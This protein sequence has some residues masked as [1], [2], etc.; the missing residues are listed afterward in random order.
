MIRQLFTESL[1]LALLGSL[2][3]L[4][5]GHTLLR[6][7]MAST[8]SPAWLDPT[9]D[10]RIIGFTLGISC[11][12]AVLFGLTPALQ[13]VRQRHRATWTRQFL[14]GA[15]VAASCVLLI[16]AALLVR[17][18]D[19]ATSA[20]PGFEY[21]QVIA[22][23]P[24]LATHGYSPT[25]ARAYM[26]TLQSRLRDLPGVENVALTN[27]PPFGNATI[28]AKIEIDGRAVEAQITHV[29]AQFFRTMRI[30]LLRGRLF[31]P[32][33]AHAVIVSQSLARR[34][35]PGQDPM[36]KQL[37]LGALESTV[38]GI[39][40]NARMVKLEDPDLA[41][42]YYP[43]DPADLP[44]MTVV[45][46]TSASA[47]PLVPIVVSILKAMDP[48]VVPA[49]EMLTTSL[50]RKLRTAQYGALAV[51]VLGL[52]A[53]LLACCG[54]AGIVAYAVSQRTKEIGIRMALGAPSSHV[55]SLVLRQFSGP[56]CAGLLVG[57]GGAAALSQ[58]LRRVLYGISSLDPVAYVSAIG[59]FALTVFL[60]ALLPAGRALRIDPTRALRCD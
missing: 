34:L 25:R 8:G 53:L 30:P 18:L 52:A 16:V 10:W 15:Q 22:I 24:G 38:V 37:P 13:V 6:L 27:I 11:T 3:G 59:I 5:V 55:V 21:Q 14:I 49:V 36:G 19:H 7:L 28:T 51:S 60:A 2:A 39:S 44:G 29:D 58:V 54:I 48:K 35:W 40:A 26:D 43:T 50:R 33:D 4:F 45:L 47:E 32:G 31:L 20:Q 46:K 57:I 12:A 56:V 9:P 1:L 41:Q 42:V 17:A 23:N